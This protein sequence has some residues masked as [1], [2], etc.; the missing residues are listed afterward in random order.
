[1]SENEPFD[2]DAFS[3][4]LSAE[5]LD[6]MG[7]DDLSAL[8]AASIISTEGADET[9]VDNA[10]RVMAESTPEAKSGPTDHTPDSDLEGDILDV[11]TDDHPLFGARP[12]A[13]VDPTTVADEAVTESVQDRE[14]SIDYAALSP[15]APAADDSDSEPDISAFEEELDSDTDEFAGTRFAPYRPTAPEADMDADMDD[16]P[17][18]HPSPAPYTPEPATGGEVDYDP[19]D[20]TQDKSGSFLSKTVDKWKSTPGHLKVATALSAVVVV[21]LGFFLATSGEQAPESGREQGRPSGGGVVAGPGDSGG[22]D[23]LPGPEATDDEG[24]LN[25]QIESV[26]SQCGEGG[27]E[28]RLAFTSNQEDA[29]VC[30]RALGIDGAVMN[31][32][33]R[34]PVTVT[35]VRMTTGYNFVRQPSGEDE[36]NKHRVITNVLWRAGGNQYPQEV[37]PSREEAVFTFPEPVSTA[38]MSM[39]VQRSVLPEETQGEGQDS[40]AFDEQWGAS[41]EGNDEGVNYATAM[42]NIQVFGT[43]G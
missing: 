14:S 29:W 21:V 26:S 38:S 16:E 36:W 18:F 8:M 17:S 9:V 24:L 6:S 23:V 41:P 22:P 34:K 39:T 13:Q 35:E 1:M 37:V 10:R 43:V 27:T 4:D 15:D 28:T 20:Y 42:Q 12:K 19:D 7:D 3:R 2:L 5:D 31:I 11:D 25:D 40:S 32:Q 33:F 30:P